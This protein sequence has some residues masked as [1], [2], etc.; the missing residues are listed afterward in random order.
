MLEEDKHAKRPEVTTTMT[1]TSDEQES[2]DYDEDEDYDLPSRTVK[3]PLK[4]PVVTTT[5]ATTF[6][7]DYETVDTHKVNLDFYVKQPIKSKYYSS[8]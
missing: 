7:G 3:P 4:N 8:S 5:Q 6:N 2:S 1:P